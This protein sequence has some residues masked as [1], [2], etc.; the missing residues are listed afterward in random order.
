M[1]RSYRSIWNESLG[2]W[3]AASEVVKAHG[4]SGRSALVAIGGAI[5]L[6]GGALF[7]PVAQANVIA[8]GTCTAPSAAGPDGKIYP[9]AA[10][11]VDGSGNYSTIA[12]CSA[13]GAGLVGA[14]VFGA[15]GK[16]TGNGGSAFGMG[17]IAGTY[18]L[19]AGLQASATGST[20][21]ALGYNTVASAPSAVA[22]GD[23]AKAS[24]DGATALG[25]RTK[26]LAINATALGANSVASSQGGLA[27]GASSTASGVSD[28]A[29]GG[30]GFTATDGAAASGGNSIAIGAATAAQAGSVAIGKGAKSAAPVAVT[31]A[32]VGATTFGSFAGATPTAGFSIGAAGT[33]R[34]LQNVAAGRISATSTDGVNGSQLYQVAAT[35]DS[36]KTA[37]DTLSTSTSV[38]IGSLSTST[39]VGLTSLSTGLGQLS[40]DVTI[41]FSSLS[42]GVSGLET[43]GEN[44]GASTAAA[45]GGGATYDPA[46]GSISAPSYTMYNADGT[47]RSVNSAGEAF[48]AINSQGIKYFHANSTGADSQATGADSVAIGPNAVAGDDNGVAIGAGSVTRTAVGTAG[49]TIGSSTLS[50]FAGA[51]PA[52]SFSVGDVGAERQVQNVAAGQL[53]ADS[54]D[55]VNGSQLYQVAASADSNASAINM[56]SS[57]TSTSIGSL[58]TSTSTGLGSLSTSTSTALA[59]VSSGLGQLS[60]STATGFS[61]LS[62]GVSSLQVAGDNLGGSTAAALGGGATYDPATGSVSAP[63]Y[64]M[65]NADGST[66]SVNSAG[67]AFDAINSQGIKYFHANS[68]GAD[69]Q[70]T[71]ADSVAIGP[72]AVAG[73]DNGVA[74]GA[75]SVTR[76]A[77]GTAGATVGSTVL[78]GFAGATPAG[79]FSVGDVGAERQVQNVAAGQLTAASTDAVNGSQLY[80]VASQAAQASDGFSD[81]SGAVSS[82]ST[83]VDSLSTSTTNSVASLS[84]STSN[85]QVAGDNLGGSTAAALGG[86]ATYDPAT[87]SISAPSYTMYNADGTTRSVN[88]AGEA[89]DAINSQGIKYFHANSTG[90]DSQATGADS[91]AIGPNAVA[92]DD[93]GVAIGAGSVT[94]AAVGTAGATIGSSTLSGFAGATPAGSFSVGDVGAERQVQNVAAGQLTVDSTDAVN[95]SQLY[96]VASQAAQA[97][98][99]Y[100]D[101]SGAV[102]SLSTGV[103]SLS[104]STASLSTGMDSLSTSTATGFSSLSTGVSSLQVAGDNQGASTAAALGGGATY[105][106]A[107]GSISAP[108]YTLYNADGTTRSVNSAG[109]AFD[110]INSQGIKYFHA[111]ST[112]ADSIASGLDSVAIGPGAVASNANGV[113]IGGGSVTRAAVATS[114][115]TVGNSTLS[116]FAGATPAGSFSVGDVGTERQVQ[117]VAAGQVSADSTDA[118]NGSQLYE[119]AKQ[120][121]QAADQYD[122]LAGTVS[123]LSTGVDSLSTSTSTSVASLSTGLDSLSTS[124]ATSVSSLSTSI[125]DLNDRVD[126]ISDGFDTINADVEQA[127]ANAKEAKDGMQSLSTSVSTVGEGAAAGLG[128]G[129]S[130]DAATGTWTAPNYTVYNQDGTTSQVANVGDAL[131]HMNT[132][133]IKYFHANS[134]LEDSRA[135]GSNAVAVG[136]ASVASGDSAVAMGNG[137]QATGTNSIAI[138]TGA[139]ATGSQAIG[140]YARAGGG[141]VALGD[142]TDAGGTPQSANANVQQGTAIG[143][144]ALVQASGG[145]ALGAGSV[146][147]RGAGVAGYV[148]VG[149]SVSQQQAVLATKSTD[150]AVSVGSDGKTRQITNVAAG[151]E[152]SD[153][154]NVAQLKAVGTDVGIAQQQ[155]THLQ[156]QID[157]VARTAYAGTAMSMAMSGTY[158]PTLYPG[159]K[160]LGVGLGSYQGETALAVNFKQ[161][162]QSGKMSWG[163]GLSTTGREVGVNAG[164][165]WKWN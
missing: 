149:A 47:T 69:S 54:T 156:G 95:G 68:T 165:G 37:I 94:R 55:A 84:T 89:F 143:Y 129:A 44:L 134:T 32:T 105:D 81:L 17:T 102:S 135:T 144:G 103:N 28:I 98:D 29:I 75:G 107:T 41:G 70:A 74:I 46:T 9:T 61:S 67:E 42:T 24:L 3:V 15:Y 10:N 137:A 39:S 34:Q 119:V 2:A 146:A 131:D 113:A 161:L 49:A 90:A 59:D 60:T 58:S 162:A 123:S 6:L 153:A 142:Q 132:Q 114:G 159:E 86:G 116:G 18:A 151:S 158:M 100:N 93:N 50:G 157:D 71:G 22:I 30:G 31:S 62:T 109:D 45:L 73:D 121:A 64:T 82:L 78:S 1:N 140:A 13:T 104:T 124:T 164:I 35:T 23:T 56:L 40:T 148:P 118:V 76:A 19:A 57:S 101:L 115:A 163:A 27:V 128:G 25:S 147:S 53:S 96:Q 36:N 112:G 106:P 51:T 77:V 120:A 11:P 108:S 92:G 5:C 154:A 97:S 80:Q 91:V 52:G 26:A 48:D 133:G 150:A 111:N 141:G 85:L 16:V 38:S 99:Q 65:Y 20:S 88:S 127:N 7:A 8:S 63:S 4:K 126:T 145:V 139:L 117:N 43:A 136:P 79:S 83:G 12:G 33:E 152:D 66:R 21:I 110:A 155:I 138:G 72:N 130:Y 87:G 122:D 125:G 160:A 14:T